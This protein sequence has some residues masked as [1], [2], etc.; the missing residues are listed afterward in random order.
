MNDPYIKIGEKYR[1][2][3]Q[4]DNLKVAYL[5]RLTELSMKDK[6][7]SFI[8]VIRDVSDKYGY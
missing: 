4:K 2:Q 7:K 5:P 1:K 8:K 3:S 6:V